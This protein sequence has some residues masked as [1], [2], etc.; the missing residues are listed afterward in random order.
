[1]VKLKITKEQKIGEILAHNPKAGEILLKEGLS[2]GCCP[3]AMDETLDEGCILHGINT[4]KI[5]KKLNKL[6]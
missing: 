6:K 1:M 3:I 4:D 5:L 2:C